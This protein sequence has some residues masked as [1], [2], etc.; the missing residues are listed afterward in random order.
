MPLQVEPVVR[1]LAAE[2]RVPRPTPARAPCSRSTALF[3]FLES[4][5]W[6][7][8]LFLLVSE[9]LSRLGVVVVVLGIVFA[10]L[11]LLIKNRID[12]PGARPMAVYRASVALYALSWLLRLAVGDGDRRP[13]WRSRC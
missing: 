2:P 10:L 3:L 7:L 9:D 13:R 1:G 5:F 8:S 11:F 4:H 6:T 12:R